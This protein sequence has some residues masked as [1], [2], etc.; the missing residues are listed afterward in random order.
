MK[1]PFRKNGLNR[2][3]PKFL[4]LSIHLPGYILFTEFQRSI[5]KPPGDS[6]FKCAIGHWIMGNGII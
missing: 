4:Y 5:M 2:W 1:N 3:N 6:E